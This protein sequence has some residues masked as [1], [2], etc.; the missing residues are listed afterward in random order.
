VDVY[1]HTEATPI[2][3]NAHLGGDYWECNRAIKMVKHSMP[4]WDYTYDE[5]ADYD[6]NIEA[7]VANFQGYPFT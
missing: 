7:F 6:E 3:K 5:F 4:Q 1:T 2:H